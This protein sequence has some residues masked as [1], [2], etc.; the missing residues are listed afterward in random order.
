MINSKI[1][2]LLERENTGYNKEMGIVFTDIQ[3]DYAKAEISIEDKHLNPNKHIHGG[4]IFALMD[5]VGGVAAIMQG[6]LITTASSDIH[7]I[8]PGFHTKKLFAEARPIKNGKNLLVYDVEAKDDQNTVL[9]KA[10]FTYFR[11]EQKLP[12]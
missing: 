8:N 3:K 2:S 6:N 4:C 11:L 12:L 9:A 10:T 7:Y 1:K 5:T